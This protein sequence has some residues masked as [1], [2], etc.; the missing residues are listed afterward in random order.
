M[1]WIMNSKVIAKQSQPECL[2]S[3]HLQFFFLSSYSLNIHSFQLPSSTIAPIPGTGLKV[4]ISNAFAELTGDWKVKKRWLKDHGSFDL[5]VEGLDISVGL[6][7][8]SDATGRPMA[9][10]SDCGAHISDVHVHISGTL[11]YVDFVPIA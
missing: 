11:G 9:T 1:A 10:T 7:L 6:K 4:T 5:K 2:S 3:P 8:G